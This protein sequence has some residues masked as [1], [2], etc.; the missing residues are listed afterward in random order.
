MYSYIAYG[1]GIQSELHLPELTE[2]EVGADVVIRL[3]KVSRSPA[4]Q[5]VTGK[6]PA[7]NEFWM[8]ADEVCFFREEVGAF[9]MRKGREIVVDPAPGAEERLIRLFVWG[10]VL[11]VTLHLRG[12]LVL[13]A[14]AVE[15]NGGAVAFLGGPGWGKSTTAAALH[16]RGYRMVTDDVLAVDLDGGNSPTALPAFPQF[17]LWPEAAIA[18]GYDLETLPLLHPEFDKRARRITNGFSTTPLT[19]ERIYVLDLGETREIEP[20]RPQ[21]TMVELVRHSYWM[22]VFQMPLLGAKATSHHFSQCASLANKV[23]ISRLRRT[24]CLPEL[25]DLAKLV[26][27]DLAQTVH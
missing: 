7:G 3:G 23:P 6:T 1:L 8:T 5:A 26:E 9:L 12:L 15:M 25:P 21:E 4:E 19:I 27:E 18:L 13:H 10:S 20:L 2:A 22:R 11:A 14:S 16:A 17:K 24:R